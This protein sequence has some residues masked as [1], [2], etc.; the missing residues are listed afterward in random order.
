MLTDRQR[1]SIDAIRNKVFLYVLVFLICWSPGN[2][3]ILCRHFL[4][5]SRNLSLPRPSLCWS[6]RDI[7]SL[8]F[9]P[10]PIA[11][12]GRREVWKRRTQAWP[13]LDFVNIKSVDL[14]TLWA[15]GCKVFQNTWRLIM[16]I[17]VRGRSF[18]TLFSDKIWLKCWKP[19]EI[20]LWGAKGQVFFLAVLVCNMVYW[21]DRT[22][23]FPLEIDEFHSLLKC[24]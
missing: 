13:F 17:F 21:L 6:Q 4:G 19:A 24:V 16:D 12:F 23:S 11:D 18:A 9:S 1:A 2:C 14:I 20:N 8:L 3:N 10:V 22:T 15:T 7:P 5:T